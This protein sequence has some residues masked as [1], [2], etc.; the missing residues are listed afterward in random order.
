MK[1][2]IFLLTFIATTASAATEYR[3]ETPEI[4]RRQVF[5]KGSLKFTDQVVNGKRVLT[6]VSGKIR[7]SWEDLQLTESDGEY[8]GE[9]EITRIVENSNYN[10]RVYVNHSQFPEFN[11][12]TSSHGMWGE[13]VVQKPDGVGSSLHAHYIF[14][15]GDH[16]GG[17][18][19]FE[20][21]VSSGSETE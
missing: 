21:A 13:F 15:S 8:V 1:A 6:D 2:L 3:C 4:S 5:S 11:A 16:M 17:V 9:F 19:D 18:V 10:P 14:Q 7:T 12:T 20:C